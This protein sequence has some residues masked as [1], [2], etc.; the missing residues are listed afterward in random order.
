MPTLV[1]R[2]LRILQTASHPMDDDELAARIGVIR[3]A[4]NQACHRLD[5]QGSLRRYVGP[6]NKIVNQVIDEAQ[7][8]PSPPRQPDL[9]APAPSAA[10]NPLSEDAVKAAVRDYLTAR[11]LH[12]EV[13]WG[14]DKGTDITASGPDGRW[15]IE[16]KGEVVSPQ[17][18]GNYFLGALGELIQRMSDPYAKYA[19]ALPDTP[20]CRGLVHRLPAL[21]RER[22][23][24]TV[25]FVDRGGTV[26]QEPNQP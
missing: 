18:Q 16:A 11:G 13:R 15:I 21:A 12:V 23:N 14:H 8:S 10:A 9:T 5:A 6:N 1:D 26:T 19:L 25:F 17:Q 7:R 4:V 24:L 22:L 3:Q 2:I 20:R